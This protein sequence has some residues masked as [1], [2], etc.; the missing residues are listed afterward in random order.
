MIIYSIG[1]LAEFQT[2]NRN[3]EQIQKCLEEYL[4]SKR[5]LFPR[6]Y[7]L[8][9]DE[10]LE[11]LSQTRNPQAVQP[12]LRK[13]FDAI[14][15][16]EFGKGPPTEPNGPP[17]VT[18]DILA[19]L[20]PEQE[21]VS[22]QKGL[23]AR[24][25]VESWLTNVE[26]SM[27]VSLRKLTKLAIAD[28]DTRPR[29]EW[30][31]KHASQVIISVSQ[32]MWCR[33]L[34]TCLSADEEDVVEAVKGAEGRCFQNLNKL[35]ELVRGE[36]P[37]LVRNIIGALI[38]IDVHARDVVTQMV[39]NK[40]SGLNDFEWVKN[41]RYYWDPEIDD[42]VIRMSNSRYIYGYEYL[43]ASPRLVITP[44]TDRCYL[45]LMGALQL[46]LGGAPAGPA[47]TGKTETTKDLAKAL[48]KQCVVFNCSE[49][50]DFKVQ[51]TF[52]CKS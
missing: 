47:G 25:N 44:L 34:T 11:I 37:K 21:K 7:F 2:N 45:C 27:M 26:E 50:L 22:L 42:C 1:L 19:M 35:A 51:S 36:L 12:H 16:L 39:E 9:N 31:T 29:H 18:N 32:I 15:K 24:G 4:E 17:S 20:S 14:A 40:V 10:L 48:A 23:K 13:C 52:T 5:L 43:G 3:L 41:L 38:T 46:D 6:F 33:D 8:S 49:G 30:A 28:F